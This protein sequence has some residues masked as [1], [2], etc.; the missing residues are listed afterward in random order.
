MYFTYATI[1]KF[2]IILFVQVHLCVDKY[3]CKT[4][5]LHCVEVSLKYLYMHLT[6]AIKLLIQVLHSL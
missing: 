5:K 4:K 2:I 1:C 3:P 6:H